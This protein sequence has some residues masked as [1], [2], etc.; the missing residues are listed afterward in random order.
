MKR[1]DFWYI[2]AESHE[3]GKDQVISRS[4]L[5]EWLA[6]FRNKEGKVSVLQD[7][8]LHRTAQLSR[9]KVQN[10][11]L[12]CPYHGWTYKGSGEVSKIPSMGPTHRPGPKC[13]K[14][15]EVIEQENF[16]YVRLS[17]TQADLK[18]FSMPCYG[19]K[20]YT[21][22]RLQNRF[23]N[24]VTNCAENFVDIPHT[25]F[26]H[27][28]I[29]RNASQEK[30]GALIERENG[31]V[32]VTYKNEK[33]NLGWFSWFLNPS[34][35]EIGHTDEFFMPN[36]TSVHYY[37]GGKNHFI[38]TSQSVP[39]NDEETLVYTD[40]TYNYGI[41]TQ[42][43][44]P[45]V[46]WQAQLIIDQDIEILDNQM[47]TI[48]KYGAHFQNSPADIIHTWIETIQNEIHE[49]RD[50]RLLPRKET[51]IEFWV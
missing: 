46:R 3:L 13:A 25:T 20:G 34:G 40:L 32:K 51:E 24:N 10:G 49:G 15:F 29:F 9:G 12:T 1:E 50:P 21:T 2:I 38:I 37:F 11:E 18:P 26:V 44:R 8:C 41:W 22:I 39:V 7:K 17:T 42:L 16:I 33:K 36:V 19:A 43:S 27:P 6:V 28:G 23:K 47:K 31:R 14:T 4:I 30:F 48:K 45:L 35:E 5:G